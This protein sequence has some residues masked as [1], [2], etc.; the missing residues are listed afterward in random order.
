MLRTTKM[1]VSYLDSVLRELNNSGT[2]DKGAAALKEEMLQ[3]E[4]VI[5]VVGLFSAGKSTLINRFLGRNYL[6]VGI[7]PETSLATELRY[8]IG[9][10]IEGIKKDGSVVTH[11]IEEIHKIKD[12]A[13]EYR[14][15]RV[16]L[17]NE[18]LKA[19]EPLVIVDMPGFDSPLDLHNQA[20]LNYLAKGVHY[21][22]VVSVE[23]GEITKSLLRRLYEIKMVGKDFTMVLNK[24]DLRSESEVTEIKDRIKDELRTEF[25][26]DKDVV[27]TSILEPQVFERVLN[28]VNPEELFKSV[29][30]ERLKI[31]YFET[32][33]SLNMMISALKHSEDEIKSAIENMD[34]S[35][36]K[37]EER[38]SQVISDI[39]IRY[40]NVKVDDIVRTIKMELENSADELVDIIIYSGEKAFMAEVAD[41]IRF[42]LLNHLGDLLE[43]ISGDIIRDINFELKRIER[44]IPEIYLGYTWIEK[45]SDRIR[46]TFKRFTKA[47]SNRTENARKVAK[48]A[49]TAFGLMAILTNIIPSIIEAAIFFLPMIISKAFEKIQKSRIRDKLVEDFIP[50]VEAKLKEQ[51]RLYLNETIEEMVDEI[52][53]EYEKQLEQKKR[54]L[55]TV[56]R[57]KREKINEIEKLI[58]AYEQALKNIQELA[59]EVLFREE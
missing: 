4:L 31:N 34:E 11:N 24:A 37:I 39:K 55:K 10:R 20:I 41:I 6:P 12:N 5:P 22:V 8:G 43:D 51:V 48:G 47:I 33:E 49:S 46:T 29:F 23:E 16:F 28:S 13:S 19:I 59:N 45:V 3:A 30:L 15:I 44:K 53:C 14:Y 52:S 58:S 40:S 2:H 17:N 26:E 35:I 18:K 38:K 7:T 54:D 42:N 25:D 1:Y 21:I 9:E 57:E 56:E 36:K 50:S 27:V 32:V